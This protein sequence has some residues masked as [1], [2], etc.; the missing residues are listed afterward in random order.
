MEV[1]HMAGGF[2]HQGR[3]SSWG[4]QG[5]K[6]EWS[7]VGGTKGWQKALEVAESI[8]AHSTTLHA[9]ACTL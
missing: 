8:E 4:R 5:V 3:R 7:E 2:K 9:K 1:G 6:L